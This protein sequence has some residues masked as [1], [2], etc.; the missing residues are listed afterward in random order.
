MEQE[1]RRFYLL[2]IITEKEINRLTREDQ[3]EH[4]YNPVVI[5]RKRYEDGEFLIYNDGSVGLWRE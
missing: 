3:K 2:P 4:V 1:E 5:G